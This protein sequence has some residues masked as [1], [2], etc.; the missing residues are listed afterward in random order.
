MRGPGGQGA[1]GGVNARPG[2]GT[3]TQAFGPPNGAQGFPGMPPQGTGQTQTVPGAATVPNGSSAP[4]GPGGQGGP[5]GLLSSSNPSATL[6]AMLQKDAQNYTWVA[7]AIG[8]Q[9]A[10]GYQLATQD[11]VMPIG[12]FNGSD[13]SPTLDEF[14]QLVA[15]GKIHYFIGG[16]G[17]GPGG[18]SGTSSAIATW[19]SQNYTAQ[20]IDGTTLYDLTAPQSNN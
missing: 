1:P 5:G 17:G 9:N 3:G 6:T 18:Q 14:K 11:P 8:S 13:P 10:S 19:V 16:S 2:T 12:G 4:G 20:T 7:A 15:A